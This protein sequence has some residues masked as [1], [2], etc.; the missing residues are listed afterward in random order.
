MRKK[1]FASSVLGMRLG[2]LYKEQIIVN[3]HTPDESEV[4]LGNNT[5]HAA[6]ICCRL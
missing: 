5:K 1:G 4:N 2:S 3:E 6:A